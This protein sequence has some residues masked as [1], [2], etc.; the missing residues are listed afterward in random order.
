MTTNDIHIL[1]GSDFIS[2]CNV[3]GKNPEGEWYQM[4]ADSM[5][6]MFIVDYLIS[7]SDR[8]GMNWGYF[9]DCNTME[10]LG[11]M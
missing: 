2:Y 3:N 6:K 7:N 1:S 4:D 5:Y 10:I 9:Y 8:H 11:L